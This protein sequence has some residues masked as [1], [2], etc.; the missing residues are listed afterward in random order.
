MFLEHIAIVE[1][2]GAIDKKSWTDAQSGATL[3]HMTAEMR[4]V[5]GANV[6][7]YPFR[8][9]PSFRAHNQSSPPVHRGCLHFPVHPSRRSGASVAIRYRIQFAPDPLHWNRC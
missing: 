3:R 7:S 1:S 8:S 5:G 2:D 4:A 9:S 6:Q